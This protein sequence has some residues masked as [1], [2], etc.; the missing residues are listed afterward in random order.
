M[1]LRPDV[2]K[3]AKQEMNI[4]SKLDKAKADEMKVLLEHIGLDK[5]CY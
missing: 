2:A 3:M 1:L 5:N 4:N